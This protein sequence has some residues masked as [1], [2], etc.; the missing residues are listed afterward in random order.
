MQQQ[1]AIFHTESDLKIILKNGE[2]SIVNGQ[3]FTRLSEVA[4]FEPDA[5]VGKYVYRTSNQE[6]IGKLMA[7]PNFNKTFFMSQDVH[8]GNGNGNG[9]KVEVKSEIEKK[10]KK[11]STC[12]VCGRTFNFPIV[13]VKH[14]QTHEKEEVNA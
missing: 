9:D 13:P 8:D 7:N 12:G 4:N 14:K 10:S 1:E 5:A 2:R 3:T 11:T 6:T